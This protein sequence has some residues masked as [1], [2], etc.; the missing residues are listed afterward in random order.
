MRGVRIDAP[1]APVEGSDAGDDADLRRDRL[2]KVVG[3]Y[4]A[5]ANRHF[6]SAKRLI[7]QNRRGAEREARLAIDRVTRAFW[8]AEDTELEDRQHELMHTIGRWVR[9]NV[10]CNLEFDEGRYARTCPIDIAHKRIGLSIGFTAR[11]LC[12]ICGDDLSEC[13]HRRGHSYWVRGGTTAARRCPVCIEDDRRETDPCTHR[14]DRLYRVSVAACVTRMRGRE[15]SWVRRP[16]NPEARLSAIPVRTETLIERFGPAFE[17]GQ[18]VRCDKCL[19]SCW[20]F[21]EFPDEPSVG[22]IGSLTGTE[23]TEAW[24]VDMQLT[25]SEQFGRLLE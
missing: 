7:G 18:P 21:V 8:W 4:R 3:G 14:N 5:E 15:V 20:G 19:G 17:V 2:L 16:A 10:G 23:M 24:E 9:E 6:A 22:A 1:D 25:M 13:P 12:S 11:R